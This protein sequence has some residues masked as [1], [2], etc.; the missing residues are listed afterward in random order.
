MVK[1]GSDDRVPAV[2]TRL[3]PGRPEDPKHT[4]VAVRALINAGYA[5]HEAGRAFVQYRGRLRAAIASW[6]E[7]PFGGFLTAVIPA[8]VLVVLGAVP[9]ALLLCVLGIGLGVI[10]RWRW[11]REMV[12]ER[13]KVQPGD[14]QYLIHQGLL[15]FVLLVA[16]ALSQLAQAGAVIGL[17]L[18][19][20]IPL[21]FVFRYYFYRS[22]PTAL[23][24]VS[25]TPAGA[26]ARSI[27]E[28]EIKAADGSA[29]LAPGG[30]GPSN[31]VMA[32]VP[33][34]RQQRRRRFRPLDAAI[35]LVSLV[36]WWLLA[37]WWIWQQTEGGSIV[38][39][40]G[41]IGVDIVGLAGG[42]L[43]GLGSVWFYRNFME[44]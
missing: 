36:V 6:P 27:V 12:L 19:L 38:P 10:E 7:I 18:A 11:R 5:P 4:Q 2:L 23:A 14:Q 8:M 30:P 21:S 1:R 13:F 34:V 35:A 28:T 24:I 42:V 29:R 26:E 17:G 22:Y 39:F 41:D 16:L 15:W 3:Q 43:I 25:N 32:Q 9:T 33:M 31:A 20:G 40:T 37:R 44:S